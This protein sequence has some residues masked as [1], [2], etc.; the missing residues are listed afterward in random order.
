MK[1]MAL[2]IILITGAC[3]LKAQQLPQFTISDKLTDKFFNAQPANKWQQVV[4]QID[5]NKYLSSIKARRSD[6]SNEIV[7]STMPVAVLGIPDK[8]PIANL[9]DPSVRYTMLIKRIG[10]VNPLAIVQKIK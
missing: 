10:I 2:I 7:Y 9:N 3:R 6:F 4:P 5:L 8:M 1:R